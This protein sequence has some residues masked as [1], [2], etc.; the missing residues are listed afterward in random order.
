MKRLAPLA[1]L[2]AALVAVGGCKKKSSDAP[3]SGAASGAGTGTGTGSIP[4]PFTGKLTINRLMGARDLVQPF[5]PWDEGFAKLQALV[6]APTKIEGSR[7]TWAVVE[8]DACAYFYVTKDNGADYK[9]DGIIVGT[10]QAPARTE[11]ADAMNHANCLKAAGVDLGPPEDPNAAGPPTDGSAVP[12]ADIRKN[13][14]PARSKWKDQK[15]SVAAVLGG[16][17]TATSGTDKYVTV[18]LKV[19]ADDAEEPLGCAFEKNAAAPDLENG[20]AVIASGK[21]AIQEWTSMG[22]G[23]VTL[24]PGLV[25]CSVVAAPAK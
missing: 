3:G 15:V 1:I 21:M 17:T 19:S 11:K 10:V 8:G 24:K 16:T 4:E 9:M 14:I 25:D 18:N 13:V 2:L 5:D 6:G 7:H 12:L 23:S 20:T 22:S